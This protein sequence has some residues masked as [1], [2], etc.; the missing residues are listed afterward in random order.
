MKGGR[1]EKDAEEAEEAEETEDT[2]EAEDAEEAVQAP[3]PEPLAQEPGAEEV[4]PEPEPEPAPVAKTVMASE[5]DA[6]GTC[7]IV[8]LMI[9]IGN[10]PFVRGSGPG[11]S[12]DAGVPMQFLAIGRWLWRSPDASAAATVQVW[13]NDKAPLGE[14]VHVRAGETRELDEDFFAG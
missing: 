7:L 2:E 13:K 6:T 14:P 11:L 1:D 4:A 12:E 9:G 8:N 10:K 3:V 5:D